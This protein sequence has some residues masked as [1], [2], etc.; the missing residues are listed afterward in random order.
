MSAI[1]R[2]SKWDVVASGIPKVLERI[3]RKSVKRREWNHFSDDEV[4][5]LFDLE[6][7]SKSFA[8]VS[9]DYDLKDVIRN[10]STSFII[11]CISATLKNGKENAEEKFHNLFMSI[12]AMISEKEISEKL[13]KREEEKLTKTKIY[14]SALMDVI[15]VDD[16]DS[17]EMVLEKLTGHHNLLDKDNNAVLIKACK[18]S[19][20]D[21]VLPLVSVGY[22]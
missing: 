5:V 6:D 14:E 20:I 22:R 21:L 12:D 3:K 4:D 11:K 13:R 8:D 9:S 15:D 17:L 2:H 1:D 19:K 18:T 10:G 16:S 7:N